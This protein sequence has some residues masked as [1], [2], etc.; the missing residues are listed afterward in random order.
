MNIYISNRHPERRGDMSGWGKIPGYEWLCEDAVV[1]E[2]LVYPSRD[3]SPRG[4]LACP[5]LIYV[6]FVLIQK[7]P[8]NSSSANMGAARPQCRTTPAFGSDQRAGKEF[9]FAT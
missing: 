5:A 3:S 9:S 8:K 2:R 7:E 1:V 6:L 4:H